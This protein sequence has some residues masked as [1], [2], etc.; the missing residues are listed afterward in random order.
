M[1]AISDGSF[2]DVATYNKQMRELYTLQNGGGYE[3]HSV[4]GS[5]LATALPPLFMTLGSKLENMYDSEPVDDSEDS[6]ALAESIKDDINKELEKTGCSDISEVQL[7]LQLAQSG[8]FDSYPDITGKESELA[9]LNETYSQKSDILTNTNDEISSLYQVAIALEQQINY[10]A[11]TSGYS[12]DGIPKY[13]E[14]QLQEMKSQLKTVTDEINKKETEKENLEKELTTLQTEKAELENEINNAKTEVVKTL[15]QSLDNLTALKKQLK[16]AEGR[17]AIEELT[18][19]ETKSFTSE[20]KKLQEAI[21]SGNKD[22]INKHASKL[23]EAYYA[24]IEAHP[25][26]TNKTIEAGYKAAE[27][28]IPKK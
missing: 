8:N 28:Y 26:V 4:W 2:R 3:T 11:A 16:Q 20:L 9:K 22:S 25:G 14:T 24:Y 6:S 18:N 1:G 13:T 5:A 17:D 23:K 27:K 7:R 21:K 15:Q 12:L 19:D 10:S